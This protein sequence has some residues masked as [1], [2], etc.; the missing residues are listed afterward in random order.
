[1]VR[2]IIVINTC[3]TLTTNTRCVLRNHYEIK[4]CA[5]QPQSFTINGFFQMVQ[6]QTQN[7]NTTVLLIT[8]LFKNLRQMSVITISNKLCQLW[9][10]T[11]GIQIC[12][13]N[14]LKKGI[15]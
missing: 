14:V 2:Y 11:I 7:L 10:D 8:T 1:M 3:K 6:H 12:I 13:I 9:K 5:D 15:V 4:S